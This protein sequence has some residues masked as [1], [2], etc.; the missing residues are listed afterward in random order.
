[1]KIFY[2]LIITLLLFSCKSTEQNPEF[3]QKVVEPDP[4]KRARQAADGGGGIFNLDKK[5][6]KKVL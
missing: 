1:M 2:T 4:F 3:D 5:K 6:I